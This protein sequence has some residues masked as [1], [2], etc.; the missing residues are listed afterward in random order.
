MS[1]YLFI[2]PLVLLTSI[3]FSQAQLQSD[4]IIIGNSYKLVSEILKEEVAISVSVPKNYKV[5]EQ[6]YPVLYVL[7][8]QW[9]FI[10]G[11]S[12]R[13]DFTERNGPMVTPEFIVVGIITD[14]SKRWD[15]SIEK[16]SLFLDFMEQ[17]LFPMVSKNFRTSN[18]R[19][20]FGWET[21]GGF[22]VNSIRR[23]S[24]MFSGYIA[25][26]PAPLYGTYFRNLES[27][28]LE[29]ENFLE[30]NK[31][32]DKFLFIGEGE[33]D[34]PAQFGISALKLLL[35]RK[36]P[37]SLQWR[38]ETMEGLS[39]QMC[40]YK[41]MQE[42]LRSYYRYYHYLTY[43]SKAEFESLGGLKHMNTF[44]VERGIKLNLDND[45]E[46]KHFTR[47]NLTF[48]AISENDYEWFDELFINFE[49]DSLLEKSFAPHINGYLLFYLKHRNIDK[50]LEIGSFLSTKFP[51][52]AQSF[53]SLGKIYYELNRMDEAEK[54]YQRAVELGSIKGDWRIE[55]Y[56]R[57]LNGLRQNK[58]NSTN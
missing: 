40:A 34:Y 13:S 5:T 16:P 6:K 2:F 29:F 42:G 3:S 38:H 20:L 4:D 49:R 10:H 32:L 28:Y 52:D 55:E 44:Y 54:Y 51:E 47:R 22:V 33:A 12:I 23:R 9:F 27:E 25:A 11:L 14:N 48:V 19:I 15:W 58:Q 26:S 35:E 57:D 8:A 56:K 7:D 30:K 53:N 36:A 41:T 37:A 1:S 18:E 39:H 31:D 21:T 24:E 17:E 45:D 46:F 50:A 43:N